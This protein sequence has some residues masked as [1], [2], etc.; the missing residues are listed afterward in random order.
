M[1]STMTD[2]ILAIT[3]A[4]SSSLP[5]GLLVTTSCNIELTACSNEENLFTFVAVL[6][7][8]HQTGRTAV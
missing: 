3:G 4:R 5:L 1:L 7:Q 2:A 8:L 6:G